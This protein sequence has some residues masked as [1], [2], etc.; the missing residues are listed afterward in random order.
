MKTKQIYYQDSYKEEIEATIIDIQES[1]GS[2]LSSIVLDQTVFFPEGGGQPG[3][4]G[5]IV[6]KKGSVKIEYTRLI[7]GEIIHQGKIID[8]LVNGDQIK[9]KIDWDWRYKYMKIHSAGHLVHDV[10]MTIVEG[11]KPLKGSHGKKAYL[12]YEGTIDVSMKEELEKNVNEVIEKDLSIT[13]K[14]ATYGELAKEC[15][16]L[17]PNLPKDKMLRMLKIG[18]FPAMPDGG[19][20]VKSTKE[21]GKVWIADLRSEGGKTVIRYGVASQSRENDFHF[22]AQ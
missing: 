4:R 14:E 17:P 6:G 9:A 21:I 5:E 11:L 1:A 2:L 13:T 12:E 19:V 10:L 15:Q 18:D 8:D 22:S 20:H 16:F 3:D 7:N